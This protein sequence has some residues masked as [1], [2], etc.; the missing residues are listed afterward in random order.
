MTHEE[1]ITHFMEN[2]K[3]CCHL[4]SFFAKTFLK[5]RAYQKFVK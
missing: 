4:T 3:F 1:I 2:L 5:T